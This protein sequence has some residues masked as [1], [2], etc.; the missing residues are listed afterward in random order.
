MPLQKTLE[1]FEL[2]RLRHIRSE[3]IKQLASCTY[4]DRHENFVLMG[5]P[6]TA[7]RRT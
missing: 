6:G 2:S 5:N 3:F 1:E 7:R 4:I